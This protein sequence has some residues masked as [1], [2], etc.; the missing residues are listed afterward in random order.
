MAILG[1]RKAS[2][3]K[4]S[5]EEA[6]EIFR[7]HFE[8]QFAPID[9]PE[10]KKD[11]PVGLEDDDEDDE[12]VGE[13]DSDDE[14]WG[15]VSGDDEEEDQDDEDDNDGVEVVDHSKQQMS[16]PVAMSKAELKRFMVRR[17]SC[18]AYS[19]SNLTFHSHHV[20][21][22]KP[23]PQKKS[24]RSKHPPL[25]PSLK[26]PPPSSP[27]TSNSVASLQNPIFSLLPPSHPT[28]LNPKHSQVVK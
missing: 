26:T 3:P 24:P 1:K 10:K 11:A 27:K 28:S 4:I 16:K 20:Y 5:P 2:E 14:E 21:Q 6:E 22:T 17:V 12:R 8:A 18:H 15:G 7:R 19:F 25:K 13:Q 23:K 9:I